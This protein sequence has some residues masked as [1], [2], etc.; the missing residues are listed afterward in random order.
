MRNLP[1]FIRFLNLSLAVNVPILL[2]IAAYNAKLLVFIG[3]WRGLDVKI[4]GGSRL[5]QGS[6]LRGGGA[7][8][9][10]LECLWRVQVES[11][12]FVHGF[13]CSPEKEGARAGQ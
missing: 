7:S 2:A 9:A 13:R 1:P 4:S 8:P 11:D 6:V 3:P 12:K 5:A 10:Y